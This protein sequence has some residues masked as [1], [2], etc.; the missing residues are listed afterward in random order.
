MME[1]LNQTNFEF[2]S[3]KNQDCPLFFGPYCPFSST[4][5]VI[6]LMG[7]FLCYFGFIMVCMF[8]RIFDEFFEKFF[9]AFIWRIFLT[10]F[11]DMVHQALVNTFI[12]GSK[13]QCWKRNHSKKHKRFMKCMK[14]EYNFKKRL[15][16][17]CLV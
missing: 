2:S 11:L 6:F 3:S 12:Q 7:K 4:M 13:V 10:N 5:E 16:S 1:D 15:A 9:D 8:W 17:L 14:I